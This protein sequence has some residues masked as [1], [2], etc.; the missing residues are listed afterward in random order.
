M[1][2][3]EEKVHGDSTYLHNGGAA[4]QHQSCSEPRDV[5]SS[6]TVKHVAKDLEV[7]GL[8]WAHVTDEQTFY[9][10]RSTEPRFLAER[11]AGT[12]TITSSLLFSGRPIP[13]YRASN[14]AVQQGP[15]VVFTS[16][17]PLSPRDFM[18]S[19][20][21]VLFGSIPDCTQWQ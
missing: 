18:H 19:C 7:P 20:L 16:R 4:R 15:S 13:V 8:I 14:M 10:P 5:V 12:T 21:F 3:R 6:D 9:G 1:A 17:S 2:V 11:Q